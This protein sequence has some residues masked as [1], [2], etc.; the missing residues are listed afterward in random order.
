MTPPETLS[1]LSTDALFDLYHNA[2]AWGQFGIALATADEMARSER[3]G[4]C[5][6]LAA[7]PRNAEAFAGYSDEQIQGI[8]DRIEQYNAFSQKG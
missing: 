6:D 5:P 1:T 2:L 4:T 7:S 3:A 8:V